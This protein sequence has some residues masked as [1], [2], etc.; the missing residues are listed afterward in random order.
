MPSTN[1]FEVIHN[2]YLRST[3][4]LTVL[5]EP[6]PQ[7]VPLTKLCL[8]KQAGWR[9]K[10]IGQLDLRK[11]SIDVSFCYQGLDSL[12]VGWWRVSTVTVKWTADYNNSYT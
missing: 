9:I 3:V 11:F 8:N 5:A 7:C 2:F 10:W 1:L 4:F 12:R 6:G